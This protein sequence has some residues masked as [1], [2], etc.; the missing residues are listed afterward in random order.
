M[1]GQLGTENPQLLRV[2]FHLIF[3]LIML[4]L[5]WTLHGEKREGERLMR[6]LAYCA[7]SRFCV[8]ALPKSVY[9][10][11]HLMCSTFFYKV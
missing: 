2:S 9:T 11:S 4:L 7:A 5:V 6:R 3:L 1:G 10:L 8:S